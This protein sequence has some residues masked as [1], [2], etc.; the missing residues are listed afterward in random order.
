MLKAKRILVPV[1]FSPESE[2]A[3]EWA[4]MIA[5]KEPDGRIQLC[6]VLPT[7]IAP[8]GSEAMVFDYAAYFKDE[9]LAVE[10]KLRGLKSG[11]PKKIFSSI[12]VG[13]GVI[14]TEIERLC[15]KHR[16][17]LVVMTTHGR[18]GL[19]RFLHGSTTEETARLALCPVLVLH[20][21]QSTRGSVEKSKTHL[22]TN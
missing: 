18:Q 20:L 12:S 6:H 1:D 8:V 17:D 11:I 22:V 15:K 3:L 21:N 10:K 13:H 4:I 9:K 7:L 14:P 19:S 5:K 2:L 16:I